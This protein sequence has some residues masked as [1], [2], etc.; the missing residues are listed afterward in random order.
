MGPNWKGQAKNFG[1]RDQNGARA[2]VEVEE[3]E[4]EGFILDMVV[5]YPSGGLFLEL[6]Q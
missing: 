1:M 2:G 5:D 4:V 3:E 6:K